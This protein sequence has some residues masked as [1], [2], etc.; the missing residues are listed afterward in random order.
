MKISNLKSEALALVIVA[1]LAGCTSNQKET[2][3]SKEAG[4]VKEPAGQTGQGFKPIDRSGVAIEGAGATFPAP[5]YTQ[6]AFTYEGLTHLKTNY[7]SVGS[8]AGIAAIEGGTVDFGASD[9][10]LEKT[11]LDQKGLTQFP[12]V[13]GGVVPVVNITGIQPGAMKLSGTVLANIYLGTIKKWNDPAIAGLNAGLNLPDKP[14]VVAYRADGSGTSWIFTSY[15]DLVSPEWH[16]KVGVGKSVSWPVG[17]GGRGNEGVASSVQQVDGAIGYVEY[18]Y[19]VQNKLTYVQL[20]NKAGKLVPPSMDTF[21]AAAS[22]ANWTTAPGFYMV[23]VDQPGDQS[24][25]ITGASFILLHKEQADREKAKAMLEFFD[26]CLRYGQ[27]AAKQIDYVPLP[28]DLVTIVEKSWVD[29]IASGGA[30][31]W[32]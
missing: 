31:V 5:I 22:N 21:A 26:W 11:E 1:L 4:Q 9:A 23:L 19:A 30:K 18:A 17:V 8:G 20:Q 29:N 7:Q 32:Q 12:M 2:T 28:M 10:P 3:P 16:T 6:W 25:P 15:L 27:D 14:I 24:W 13:I